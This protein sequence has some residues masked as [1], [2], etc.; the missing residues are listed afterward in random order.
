MCRPPRAEIGAIGRSSPIQEESGCC[1]LIWAD[2]YE[3]LLI[4]IILTSLPAIRHDCTIHVW[5][6]ILDGL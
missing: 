1:S 4:G 5:V 2:I 3:D 6:G